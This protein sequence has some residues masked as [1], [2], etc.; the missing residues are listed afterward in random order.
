MTRRSPHHVPRLLHEAGI[1]RATRRRRKAT[2]LDRSKKG[3]VG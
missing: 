2:T 3:T 1:I